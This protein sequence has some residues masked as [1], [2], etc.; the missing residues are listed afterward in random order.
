MTLKNKSCQLVLAARDTL[1]ENCLTGKCIP[2]LL[3][4]LKS[5]LWML[6]TKSPTSPSPRAPLHL[7]EQ[8]CIHV[9]P[10]RLHFLMV[11]N[12]LFETQEV[13]PI[14]LLFITSVQQ[15]DQ[16]RGHRF[17]PATK[18]ASW[19]SKWAG[20]DGEGGWESIHYLNSAL[21]LLW[22]AHCLNG[23]DQPTITDHNAFSASSTS[24]EVCLRSPA[25]L[26]ISKAEASMHHGHEWN[27]TATPSADIKHFR[28]KNM[29]VTNNASITI[30]W[31]LWNLAPR[32]TVL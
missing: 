13:Q 29:T 21:A 31:F 28:Q 24:L 10:F 15:Q 23:S 3:N 25:P 22:A 5:C 26:H 9:P 7:N 18:S 8:A 12:T 16:D 20:Q 19:S 30:T 14:G 4:S 2:S 11:S 17:C 27:K 6:W 1:T 32:P